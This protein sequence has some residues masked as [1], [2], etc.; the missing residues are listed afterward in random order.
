MEADSAAGEYRKHMTVHEV[1]QVFD[2]WSGLEGSTSFKEVLTMIAKGQ[3]PAIPAAW[4]SVTD[5]RPL[6]SVFGASSLYEDLRH[7][8]GER[9]PGP[10]RA[11]ASQSS[12]DCFGALPPT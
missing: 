11:E 1:D 6:G 10:T 2:I 8:G 9:G 12:P 4:P 5:R 7:I 3:M